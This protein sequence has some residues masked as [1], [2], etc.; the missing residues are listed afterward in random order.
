MNGHGNFPIDTMTSLLPVG[1]ERSRV[2][3]FQKPKTQLVPAR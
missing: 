2:N 3:A 1:F